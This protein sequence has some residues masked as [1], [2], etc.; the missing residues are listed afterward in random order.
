[1]SVR[2]GRSA[3]ATA[4]SMDRVRIAMLVFNFVFVVR[5]RDRHYR[6]GHATILLILL[7]LLPGGRDDGRDSDSGRG[8]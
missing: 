2:I 7:P 1:V 6:S 3:F 8:E 4:T 5:V